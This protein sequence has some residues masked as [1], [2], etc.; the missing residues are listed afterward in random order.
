MADNKSQLLS[1]WFGGKEKDAG[2]DNLLKQLS[3]LLDAQGRRHQRVH[4]RSYYAAREGDARRL[5][6]RRRQDD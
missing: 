3:A 2:V 4:R 6:R 5:A 1:K